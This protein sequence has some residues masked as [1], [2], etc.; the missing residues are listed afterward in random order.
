MAIFLGV[1][2]EKSQQK[3]T[4]KQAKADR[5]KRTKITR[6]MADKLKKAQKR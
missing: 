5:S 2:T 3:T 4:R 1:T 6:I